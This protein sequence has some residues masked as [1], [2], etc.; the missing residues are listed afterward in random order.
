MDE[1][2]PDR[3]AYFDRE[4]DIA[5]FP[6]APA[7][8]AVGD[9]QRWGLL[10]RDRETGEVTGIE[11]WAAREALPGCLLDNLPEPGRDRGIAT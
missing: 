7:G 11:I 1:S 4:A 6:T 2:S 5:W 8:D 3:F 10:D 9:E